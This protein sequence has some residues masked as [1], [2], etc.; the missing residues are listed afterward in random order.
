MLRFWIPLTPTASRLIV[1][2]A[3][4]ARQVSIC[5][6]CT[7]G[8]QSPWRRSGRSRREQRRQGKKTF[9]AKVGE[10][11]VR[12]HFRSPKIWVA[13][14][15]PTLVTD[16]TRGS[17]CCV[18]L[19]H[20]QAAGWP[21]CTI[22]CHSSEWVGGLRRDG[23]L[24]GHQDRGWPQPHFVYVYVVLC[25]CVCVFVCLFVCLCLLFLGLYNKS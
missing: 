11:E 19:T 15:A 20:T 6:P 21:P 16:I 8:S 18:A 2:A 13:K 14:N 9:G 5:W 4:A 25:V 17:R 7:R 12:N 24:R 22:E 3:L 23:G 10:R 1:A